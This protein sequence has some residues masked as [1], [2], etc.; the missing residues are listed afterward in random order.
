M[1]NV[2]KT[3]RT[4]SIAALCMLGTVACSEG[5]ERHWHHHGYR[6]HYRGYHEHYHGQADFGPAMT[7][8]IATMNADIAAA[9]LVG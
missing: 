2:L 9:P 4:L 6:E 1:T 7:D 3:I 8:D 5:R